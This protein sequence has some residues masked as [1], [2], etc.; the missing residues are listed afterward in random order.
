M[1]ASSGATGQGAIGSQSRYAQKVKV[2]RIW[3]VCATRCNPIP[4]HPLPSR[5][6]FLPA[7]PKSEPSHN[8]Y[9]WLDVGL[10]AH[11][12]R[13][14][15]DYHQVVESRR[16]HLPQ[17]LHLPS[18]LQWCWYARSN[19]GVMRVFGRCLRELEQCMEG[20][21]ALRYCAARPE[22]L[23]TRNA[24]DS[25]VDEGRSGCIGSNWYGTVRLVVVAG[26]IEGED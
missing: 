4:A 20:V 25:D 17:P 13:C 14:P 18:A 9:A 21:T 22:M 12:R 10:E 6:P 7:M 24:R 3:K 19:L 11:G 8:P 15:L 26:V 2:K 5:H 23:L 16:D 1:A